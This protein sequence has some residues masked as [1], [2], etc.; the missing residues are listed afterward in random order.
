MIRLV[1]FFLAVLGLGLLFA[2]VADQPGTMVLSFGG[3]NYEL[4][5]VLALGAV[6]ALVVIILFIWGLFS[7]LL[8]TPA[9]MSRFFETRRKDRGY[10]ALSQGLIAASSGDVDMARS[11]AR[12]SGKLLKGE[13]LVDLLATQTALLDGKREEARINFEKMLEDDNTR[14]V[15]LR[16]L[17]LEAERQGEAQAAREYAEEAV[18]QAPA[19]PWAGSAKLRYQAMDGNWDE[20]LS[21]LEANRA[22]GLIDKEKAKRQR[23]VLLTAKSIS[24]E[25]TNP[26]DAMKLAREAHKL[27]KD[28]VPA[29]TAYAKAA[30]RQGDIRGA[31]KILEATWKL[32]PHP[33]IAEALTHVRVGDSVKDRLDRARKLVGLRANHVEGNLALAGAAIDAQEWDM[34]RKALEPVLTTNPTERACL[35]MADLEE[36]ETGNVGRMRDWLSRAVNAAP[37]P[38]WTADGQTSEVWLP[39]SPVTGEIDAF[40]WKVPVERIGVEDQVITLEDLKPAEPIVEDVKEPEVEAETADTETKDAKTEADDAEVVEV[41]EAKAETSAE[42]SETSASDT[43]ENSHTSNEIA[44][45]TADD[46]ASDNTV[47]FPLDRRPDDPGVRPED[48]TEKKGFKLF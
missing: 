26:D 30:S 3:Y 20:A 35:L 40:E 23:A 7:G 21:A 6:I 9:V 1:F 48:K 44:S 25:P 27:A 39:L 8:R 46:E 28:L 43:K 41:V 16:G 34:A 37:D 22:A 2:W 5:L 36:A 18:K 13:P 45:E 15:A 29:A 33:E 42:T 31:T 24:V 4:P 32:T 12:E 14:L 38:A 19:L 10:K 17:F 11:L 47:K